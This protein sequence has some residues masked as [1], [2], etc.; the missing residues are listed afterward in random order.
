MI[1][2]QKRE[3][4]R[5]MSAALCRYIIDGREN[6]VQPRPG[7]PLG[8]DCYKQPDPEQLVYF[9]SFCTKKTADILPAVIQDIIYKLNFFF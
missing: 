6:R 1:I 4:L 5:S 8:K 2:M 9:L 7:L 3:A